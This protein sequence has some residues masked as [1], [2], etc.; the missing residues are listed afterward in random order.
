[1][2][3]VIT[4]AW[5]GAPLDSALVE[6]VEIGK[7][8]KTDSEGRLRTGLPEGAHTVVVSHY[9]HQQQMGQLT[10]LPGL[11]NYFHA[12]LVPIPFA[13]LSL[14]LRDGDSHNALE[15]AAVSIPGLPGG[16]RY[17]DA[18]GVV[19]WG[20]V[21]L[22][23]YTPT[24][25]RWGYETLQ[26]PVEVSE[27][28]RHSQI[29]PVIF[30]ESG[31]FDNCQVDQ[32]WILGDPD[33]DAT[34]GQWVRADPNPSWSHLPGPTSPDWDADITPYGYAFHTGYQYPHGYQ[35]LYDVDGGK[36]TLT[37]PLFDLRRFPD[38][39]L[40]YFRWFSNDT[41]D[42]PGEDPFLVELSNDD[43]QRWT[44]LE[45]VWISAREWVPRNYRIRDH[46]EPTAEMRLRFIAQD[47]GGDSVVEAGVDRVSIT[48]TVI[49]VEDDDRG[50]TFGLSPPYPNPAPGAQAVIR[51]TLPAASMNCRMD[52]IDVRGRSVQRL[53]EGPRPAG[54]HAVDLRREN[55][56][57]AALA[58]G[59][60]WVRLRADGREAITKLV[61]IP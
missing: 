8:V 15:R 42:Y 7:T 5:T 30:M 4:E 24:I 54:R 23:K 32:G 57:G 53:M 33:D 3:W 13:R 9:G 40:I 50:L 20:L 29:E 60:Y 43:G 17:T 14:Q 2:E 31:M 39:E 55:S 22:G 25:G 28:P 6:F 26:L 51:Y 59:I 48:G 10:V 44:L 56:V 58:A 45:E 61:V 16:V 47:H 46:L 19:D 34:E 49:A 1:L 27:D 11:T 36:T 35:F 52:L 18:D 38:P 41:F 37:S 12:Q 21:P